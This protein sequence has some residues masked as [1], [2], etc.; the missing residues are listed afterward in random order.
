MKHKLFLILLVT[1]LFFTFANPVLAATPDQALRDAL[2]WLTTQQNADGGFS[3]GFSPDSGITPTAEAVI[4]LAAGGRDAGAVR[5]SQGASPLD[6]LYQ[7]ATNG[8][9]EG[10]GTTAKVVMALTAAGLDSANFAGLNLINQLEADY[11]ADSGAYGGSIFDQA[12]AVLALANVGQAVPAGAVDYLMA[13]QTT[14]GAWN[15]MG[16]TAALSGD[17]NTTAL[18]IQA[19]VAASRKDDTGRGLAYLRRLQNDDGGWPYQNPSPYGTETD[20]N[21]TAL[22]L[23]AIYAVGQSPGDWYVDGVDPLGALL[24]LQNAN[25]SFSYQASFR[26]DNVLATLQAI[27]AVAGM[28]LAQLP[29][30]ATSEAPGTVVV[31]QDA[32]A[33]PSTLPEAGGVVL[34]VSMGLLVAGL[35]LMVVGRVLKQTGDPALR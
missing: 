14:D 15:F 4:A 17:T 34:S 27:P 20:A 11:D 5:S 16:D 32:D 25:G 26:G 3:D 31:Q 12:L 6:F 22:V 30:A 19:L 8:Q 33:P 18:V 9:I 24:S 23:Q 2:E 13:Y 28:T 7:Q 29:R 35:I 10:I 1:A 21:S